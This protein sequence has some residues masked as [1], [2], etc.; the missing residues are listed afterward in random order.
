MRIVMNVP[1]VQCQRCPDKHKTTHQV[2]FAEGLRRHT[3]NF[4]RYAAAWLNR[5]TIQDVVE[6]TGLAWDKIAQI[7]YRRSRACR[8]PASDRSVAS[9]WTR[10]MLGRCISS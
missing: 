1:R 5:V 2:R 4:E 7:D 3:Q 10:S 6:I 8:D 9:L